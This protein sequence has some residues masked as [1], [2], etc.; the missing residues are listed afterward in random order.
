MDYPVFPYF[1]DYIVF[2]QIYCTHTLV[3]S[4]FH[5]CQA[6]LCSENSHFPISASAET[7]R[8]NI[9]GGNCDI[10]VVYLNLS[11]N[12]FIF[13]HLQCLYSG[14]SKQTIYAKN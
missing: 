8:K 11:K 12:L 13:P 2:Y 3:Y 7:S 5:R 9:T 6:C 1:V 14:S 4:W 10:S